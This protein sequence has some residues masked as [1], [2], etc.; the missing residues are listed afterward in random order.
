MSENNLYACAGCNDPCV[1]KVPASP[2][3]VCLIAS[4]FDRKVNWKPILD[5]VV[6][7]ARID[8]SPRFILYKCI[9]CR[10]GCF[11]RVNIN[12][13]CLN[14]DSYIYPR[15]ETCLIDS[16]DDARV[17]YLLLWDS[18]L[19]EKGGIIAHEPVALRYDLRD[20]K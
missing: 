6:D 3:S 8:H 17:E 11:V 9:G 18:R 7:S 15:S 16:K 19:L 12:S 1:I 14:N 2:R 5:M 20:G 4:H 10:S 13:N